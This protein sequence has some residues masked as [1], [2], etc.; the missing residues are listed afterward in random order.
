MPK[1]YGREMGDK[2]YM[3]NVGGKPLGKRA[4]Q[5]DGE[6]DGRKI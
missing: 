2:G 5:K 6:I 1:I 4:L 3:Q